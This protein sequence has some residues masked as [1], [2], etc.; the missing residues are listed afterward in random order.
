MS[1]DSRSPPANKDLEPPDQHSA[2]GN[3]GDEDQMDNPSPEGGIEVTLSVPASIEVKMVNAATLEDYEVWF[4]LS[5]LAGSAFSGFLVATLQATEE[6]RLS[7]LLFTVFIGLLFIV[8]IY[9]TF[10]KRNR[11][12][13]TSKTRAIPYIQAPKKRKRS[14]KPK[15][16]KKKREL[17]HD[18]KENPK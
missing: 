16:P 5:S 6:K 7:W 1:E 11:L 3:E 12:K 14:T 17:E 18:P 15:E 13:K 8:F 9:Q 10:T 4:F 2:E